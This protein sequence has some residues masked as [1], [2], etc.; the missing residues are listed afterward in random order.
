MRRFSIPSRRS[1]AIRRC[2]ASPVSESISVRTTGESLTA[3]PL[4]RLRTII[5]YD[6]I[7]VMDDGKI[8]VRPF[9]R[10]E[11]SMEAD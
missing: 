4:D 3:S 9:H 11:S 6:R 10:G 1:S 8:A 7:L 2:S 5:S